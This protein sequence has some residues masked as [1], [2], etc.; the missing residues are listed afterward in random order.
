MYI[1]VPIDIFIYSLSGRMYIYSLIEKAVSLKQVSEYTLLRSGG[2]LVA[3][4]W[5]LS[6]AFFYTIKL[7][8]LYFFF[9]SFFF[10]LM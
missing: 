6:V 7:F 2:P 4:L 10:I 5:S 8:S 9:F 1:H 3:G